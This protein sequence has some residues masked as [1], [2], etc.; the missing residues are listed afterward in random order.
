VAH[1]DDVDAIAAMMRRYAL[2]IE[3]ILA[4]AQG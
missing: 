3:E 1:L 4:M 2:P